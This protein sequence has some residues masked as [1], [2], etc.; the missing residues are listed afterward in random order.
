MMVWVRVVSACGEGLDVGV[1]A[2]QVCECGG[3]VRTR[4]GRG[5]G[6]GC[7]CE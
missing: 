3:V 5:S 1:S 7:G 6:C 4:H 2:G